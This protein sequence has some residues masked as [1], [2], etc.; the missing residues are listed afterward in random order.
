M[1]VTHSFDLVQVQKNRFC[2]IGSIL[3]LQ[4]QSY[5]EKKIIAFLQRHIFLVMIIKN[6]CIVDTKSFRMMMDNGRIS[7]DKVV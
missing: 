7:D 1:Y 6:G 3:F 4:V 5:K 2:E